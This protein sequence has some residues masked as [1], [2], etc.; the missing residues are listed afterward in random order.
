MNH[1]SIGTTPSSPPGKPTSDS[2]L[3]CSSLVGE[4]AMRGI[5]PFAI[6]G[7]TIPDR[8]DGG[9]AAGVMPMLS[10]KAP[11]AEKDR[12]RATVPKAAEVSQPPGMS[13]ARPGSP[14]SAVASPTIEEPPPPEYDRGLR[15]PLE[16]AGIG[17]GGGIRKEGA[18][19][20]APETQGISGGE[21]RALP[22]GAEKPCVTHGGRRKP[23]L[24]DALP[25]PL[26]LQW[27]PP[28]PLRA[29]PLPGKRPLGSKGDPPRPPSGLI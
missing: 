28:L 11:D 20:A 24:S 27:W 26:L 13:M 15:S 2:W 18:E 10:P 12:E 21:L 3:E 9:A 22:E 6:S 14:L 5:E 17:G 29:L 25:S 4:G 19:L 1:S 7:G 16:L 8:H 23:T